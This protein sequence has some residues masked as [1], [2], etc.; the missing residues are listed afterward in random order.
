[1]IFGM[2]LCFQ[3]ALGDAR[4]IAVGDYSYSNDHELLADHDPGMITRERPAPFSIG[5]ACASGAA[6]RVIRILR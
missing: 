2:R 5:D 3:D 6:R 4:D 1:M